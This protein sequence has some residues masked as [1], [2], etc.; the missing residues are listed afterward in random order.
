MEIE[1][2]SAL[3]RR[4]EAARFLRF[5][6]IG[7][8]NT[9]VG[10][11]LFCMGVIA[12]LSAGLA[13]LIATGLGVL[14]NFLTTGRMVFRNRSGSGFLRFA[15]VYLV[16][17]VL[18]ALA[19]HGLGELHLSPFVSQAI[20]TPFSVIATYLAMRSFVFPEKVQ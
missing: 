10:Y 7:A 20:I 11:G 19:L 18:N 16:V 1:R 17:Y 15:T 14:L 3:A 9:A 12:G 4:P 6:A 5:L 2:W 13:L 8:F